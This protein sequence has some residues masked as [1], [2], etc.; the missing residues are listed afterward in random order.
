MKK[1]IYFHVGM[2]KV[3]S[4]YLQYDVFPK[5]RGTHYIPTTKYFSVKEIIQETDAPSF[6]ISREFDQQMEREVKKFAEIFPHT[7]AI[8]FL[9]RHDSWIASQ[10]RRFAK[11]GY[12][13][14]YR[15]FIDLE[16]DSGR[17]KKQDLVFFR[18]IE[19]LQKYFNEK[20]L[21]LFYDEL[22]S[23]PFT[24]IDKIAAFTKTSYNRSEISL[25][26]K[27]SSYEE[28]QIRVMQ[29]AS[30]Y[31]SFKENKH[32]RKSA[33]QFL[34]RLPVLGLRYIILYAAILIPANWMSKKEII[35]VKFLQKIN[36]LTVDDWQKCITYAK[37]N[38]P[39]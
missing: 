31:I 33:F 18:N 38:N 34:K 13:R 11:N 16:N 1:E 37:E 15:E 25:E 3:A 24:C 22:L 36:A 20:P 21:V 8:L 35:P 4:K 30:K 14:D 27:H 9:R 39:V 23:S 10:Y 32:N 29:F 12:V 7:K 28:K 26:K 5:L 17:F 19:I 6:L 2:G